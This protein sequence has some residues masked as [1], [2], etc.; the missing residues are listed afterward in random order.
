[1]EALRLVY[2]TRKEGGQSIAWEDQARQ[3]L[4]DL[5]PDEFSHIGLTV[6]STTSLDTELTALTQ[7][8]LPLM[9]VL[10]SVMFTFAVL[11]SLSADWT[12]AK[13]R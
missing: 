2:V 5:D 6:F 13:V 3:A 10:F 9:S 7:E 4:L 11:V 1:M 8:G 12:I